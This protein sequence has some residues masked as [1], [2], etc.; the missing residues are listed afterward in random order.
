MTGSSLSHDT[1]HYTVVELFMAAVGK[2]CCW[3][4][5]HGAEVDGVNAA[6]IAANSV[7]HV[8]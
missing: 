6:T 8:A 7:D 5:A 3:V 2:C 1:W 4:D